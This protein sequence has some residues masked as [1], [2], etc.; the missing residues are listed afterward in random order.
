MY[1]HIY[2]YTRW[3]YR[4]RPTP[5][6]TWIKGWKVWKCLYFCFWLDTFPQKVCSFSCNTVLAIAF[7]LQEILWYWH[8]QCVFKTFLKK[9]WW[10]SKPTFDINVIEE[11][12]H[13]ML[14]LSYMLAFM[15]LN[16]Y[17]SSKNIMI[18]WMT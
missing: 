8:D 11:K 12:Q 6:A 17:H 2:I 15:S 3:I 10:P 7:S 5:F 1:I 9:Q 13:V 16:G 14:R 4:L 18:S